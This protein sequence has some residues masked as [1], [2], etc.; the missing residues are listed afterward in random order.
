MLA[1]YGVQV[2]FDQ[3]KPY[4]GVSSLQ[5]AHLMVAEKGIAMNPEDLYREKKSALKEY[6]TKEPFPLME[7]VRELVEWAYEEGIAL[8]VVSASDRVSVNDSVDRNGL[9]PYIKTVITVEDV[10]ES[11]AR[12]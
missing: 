8:A 12:P 9:R 5:T 11:Q 1:R 2:T 10:A 7:G 6:L 3:F 4:I